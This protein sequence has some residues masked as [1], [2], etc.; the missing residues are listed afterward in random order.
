MN[1]KKNVTILLSFILSINLLSACSGGGAKSP[2]DTKKP[3]A[4]ISTTGMPIAPEKINLKMIAG[5]APTTAS[6]W[7][8]VMLWQEY[9]KLT[10]IHVDWDMIPD[11]TLTE[12]RNIMLAGGNY[13]DA[14]F[15]AGIPTPDLLKYGSQGTFIKLNDLI[16]K[17]APNIKK[18][19]NENPE[20]RKGLTM[21]DGNIYSFPTVF[22]PKF[23]SV[24]SG[25]KV[26]LKKEW[27]DKLNLK[28]PETTED[29]YN[30]LKAF[31]EKDPN[32]NGQADE[33][34]FQSVG[35][36]G[37]INY[38][39]GAWG[40]GT[41]GSLHA[42]VDMDSSG[43]LRFIPTDPKY[44]EMLQYVQKLYSEKLIAEDIFTIKSNQ[45]YATGSKGL[46]GATRTTSP[47]TLMNQPGYIGANALKGP[48]GDQ[49]YTAVGSPL[50]DPGAFVITDKN[51]HPEATVRWMDYLYGEEGSKMFFMGFEGK[52]YEKTPSG[53]L[54]YTKEITANPG[55]LTFE[56][57]LVK[58]VVW[59]GGGY[60]NMVQQ[61]FFKGAESLPESI[62]ATEKFV[63]Y[64]PKEIWPTFSYTAE[65]N[66]KMAALSADINTY[67]TEMNAKFVTSKTPFSEWDSYVETLKKM[68]LNEYM[69]IYQAAYDRYKK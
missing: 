57:A 31:K 56:Q 30:M 35:L 11:E 5:K 59:P 52:S 44:K 10:N 28:E 68:K 64:I 7:N 41:R 45:F 8:D 18:L 40:L 38:F 6:N 36:P 62:A 17:Y 54:Q 2:D 29:F 47:Q 42:N 21:P 49:V 48:H 12:K 67:V 9:E 34:P 60:P 27:L 32:G 58:Y 24:L 51:K 39:K 65:E 20:V 3:E 61:K 63:K 55:G 4:G 33:I 69:S 50:A 43:K 53:E 46:Y 66:Q 37:I 25:G 13:P 1:S 22:D 23:T 16:D 19:L 26:W 14:F 15:T